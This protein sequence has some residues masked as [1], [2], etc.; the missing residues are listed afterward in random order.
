MKNIYKY[1]LYIILIL[2][3]FVSC[4][5]VEYFFSRSYVYSYND[6]KDVILVNNKENTIAI[7]YTNIEEQCSMFS[8][9]EKKMLYDSLCIKNNDMSYNKTVLS[10]YKTHQWVSQYYAIIPNII[11]IDIKSEQD[12]DDTH[13]AG[14][15]LNDII[16]IL[17][18]SPREYIDKNYQYLYKW[19]ENSLDTMFYNSCFGDN[20]VSPVHCTLSELELETLNLIGGWLRNSYKVSHTIAYLYFTQASTLSKT[21]NLTVTITLSDGRVFEKSIE[22]TFN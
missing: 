12:F 4:D 8:K 14:E 18:Y 7:V 16:E 9:K 10:P 11:N 6:F 2:I 22:K 15:S 13:I 1:I 17:S 21:H 3:S 20:T 5:R 19:N